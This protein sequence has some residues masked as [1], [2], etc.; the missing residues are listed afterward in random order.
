LQQLLST[1]DE[2]VP[3]AIAGFLLAFLVAIVAHRFRS[4]T[5][6]GVV[7]TTLVGGSVVAGSGWWAGVILILYFVS[8]SGLSFVT[9]GKPDSI[10]QAR[11]K[12]RDAWQVL[13]N[14][15]AAAAFALAGLVV[16]NPEAWIMATV[17]SIA[18]A[19]ADTWATE[20]G[21]FSRSPPRLVTTWRQVPSGTSGAISMA[22]TLASLAAATCIALLAAGPGLL[23]SGLSSAQVF[24]VVTIAGILGSLTDSILGATLQE[25]RWCPECRKPTEQR[26]HRCGA[27][28]IHVGGLK[29]MTNDMVNCLAVCVSGA[30]A[31]LGTI[32]LG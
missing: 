26:P 10:E 17:G 30:V 8:S 2:P 15:G 23:V 4:L 5:G 12:Q 25:R 19:A 11:G 24:G 14:G 1:M 13:A 18:G 7:A 20:L 28:T 31:G 21:R 29:W 3:R 32:L 9:R 27:D 16:S 22:G 6:S